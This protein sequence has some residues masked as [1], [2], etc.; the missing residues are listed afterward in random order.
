MSSLGKRPRDDEFDE[1]VH[2]MTLLKEPSAKRG[3]HGHADTVELMEVA[4]AKE[5][6]RSLP[7]CDSSTSS[8]SPEAGAEPVGAHI[9]AASTVKEAVLPAALADALPK[10]MVPL[11][12]PDQEIASVEDAVI[13]AKDIDAASPRALSP[14]PREMSQGSS[15]LV[16]IPPV[17]TSLAH[18]T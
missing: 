12:V 9:G 13:D 7:H 3:K 16:S 14:T 2:P 5:A 17:F 4:T 8:K 6:E 15:E 18:L 1:V 10:V 11:K